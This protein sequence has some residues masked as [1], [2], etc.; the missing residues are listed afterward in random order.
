MKWYVRLKAFLFKTRT[1]PD[2]WREAAWQ[3]PVILA[4]AL[5]FA[6]G[7]NHWRSDGIPFDGNWS[8]ENR[9]SDESGTSIVI[10][11]DRAEKLFEENNAAFVDARSESQYKE[12]HIQGAVNIP[13]QKVD[14]FFMDA[15][16]RLAAAQVI[17]T[18][19]DGETCDL[20]HEL[21]LFFKEMGFDKVHVLVNGWTVWKEAGLPV[22]VGG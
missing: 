4:A 19:C 9:F 3:V 21:A 6:V 5:L 7:A 22:H 2:P 13:W 8:A 12:G 18:Y 16:D 10:S 20:S 15:Y 1:R 17:I 14:Q 11:L